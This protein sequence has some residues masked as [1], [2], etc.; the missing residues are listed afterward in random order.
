LPFVRWIHH[1]SSSST[2]M[3]ARLSNNFAR[4]MLCMIPQ[5]FAPEETFWKEAL[6]QVPA[7][8]LCFCISLNQCGGFLKWGY[9]QIINLNRIFH[10]KPSFLGYPHFGK[11][12]SEGL[13][14]TLR[15]K[16]LEAQHS[17]MTVNYRQNWWI[18]M[19]ADQTYEPFW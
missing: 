16:L 1:L 3:R 12:P 10:C 19:H 5:V 7:V 11:P 18:C 15:L 8:W 2:A 4:T 17:D 14:F 13:G 9:S 6:V